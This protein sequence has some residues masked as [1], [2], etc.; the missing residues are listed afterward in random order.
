[1]SETQPLTRAIQIVGTLRD[2][3]EQLGVTR[4][5]IWQ[6]RLPNRK[7]PAEYC[8]SIERITHGAVTCEELRPDVEW[9]YLR[10]PRKRRAA[11]PSL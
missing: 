6:W 11:A 7:V 1:M 9:A 3:A 8:P 2:L 4:A 10:S 5:A